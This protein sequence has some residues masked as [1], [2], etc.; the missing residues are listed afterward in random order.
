[1]KKLLFFLLIGGMV[2]MSGGRA[3]A[4]A[5]GQTRLVLAFYYAWFNTGS[6]G[7]G[8]TPFQPIQPY[9][10]SDPATIQ[11]HVSE[12]QAAGIDGFV[13]SWYGPS[14]PYTNGNFQT[15]L[16]TA[17]ASGFQAAVDFEPANFYANHDQRAAGIT[18]LLN[19]LAT[20]PAY[21]RVDGRPV[22]FFWANWLY[23]VD[24]WAYIRNLA[25]PG[26]NAIWIAEGAH[27]DYLAV[28]DGLHFYNTS[29]ADA[30][31]GVA[32]NWGNTTRAATTTYGSYKYW[33]ATAMPG[34]DET[35][36]G[37][38]GYRDRAG[39]AYYQTSFSGAA[40]SS[41]DMLIITSYNEWPEGSNIEPS[42]EFGNYYLDL[43]AQM[44]ATYKSGGVPAPGPQPTAGPSPTPAPTKTPGPS[45]TPKPAATA[46]PLP[47]P[48]SS[49]TPQPDGTIVYY[50]VAGDTLTGIANRF[51]IE[52]QE[53]YT[54]NNLSGSSIIGVGQAIVLGYDSG[55]NAAPVI[56]PTEPA[57]VREDGAIIHPVEVGETLLG[58][59]AS[60][61]LT[62]PEL[63]ALNPGLTENS[64]LQVGQEIV[65]GY[66]LQ[67]ESVGG[68][69]DL[70]MPTPTFTTT[71]SPSP[72]PEPTAPPTATAIP[73]ASPTATAEAT[74][75]A[76]LG[77]PT[78]SPIP[79]EQ[80]SPQPAP[81][82]TVPLILLGL[83]ALL[84]L[85]GIGAFFIYLGRR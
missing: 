70:P 19:N 64:L 9:N 72:S 18:Y 51:Q 25:D 28:F 63:L 8:K 69:T 45:P 44:S 81:I 5:Q 39:G 66:R 27:A 84:S 32:T 82:A 62:L 54:L 36:L 35:L 49:P 6:F 26:H 12:A 42:L 40:A 60:V 38:S 24:D 85:V 53:L 4:G 79:L 71:P 10:S 14:D 61:G 56:L 55:R 48:L 78:S 7:P 76:E 80:A 31:G 41:P 67:P 50:V 3:P 23:S 1:M 73:L 65:V 20:H 59:A 2:M 11:R 33:V 22:I 75:I 21:L 68:S 29:W 13:Q 16:N 46:T 52:L 77:Q 43:T 47:T 57:N 37:R 30:P 15:L 74:S 34:F 83:V 58:I 17:S